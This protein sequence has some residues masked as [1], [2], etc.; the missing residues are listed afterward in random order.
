MAGNGRGKVL[1]TSSSK[2]DKGLSVLEQYD[3][4][5]ENTYR[6]RGSLL[7]QTEQGWKMIRPYAGSAKR[8]EKINEILEHLRSVGHGNVDLILRNKEEQLISTDKEG[9]SYLVKDW[10]DV[11]ECEVR[12]ETDVLLCMEEMARMHR[13]MYLPFDGICEQE[14]LF[15]LY[16][17][18]NQQ[19][20]KIRTYVRGRKQK[21]VFE[22][23]FLEQVSGYLE[24]GDWAAKPPSLPRQ[25][26]CTAW[27]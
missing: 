20:K 2:Y 18:H 5:S 13:D 6:G 7:C 16:Q 1:G 3:L 24:L 10:W 15:D 25:A 8:L 9:Y 26:A 27:I 11:R 12:S 21:S 22:Y 19:L 14:N 17:K 23:K 4:V